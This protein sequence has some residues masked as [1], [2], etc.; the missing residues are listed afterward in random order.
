MPVSLTGIM[1]AAPDAATAER[2]WNVDAATAM[3][4]TEQ[5]AYLEVTGVHRA[6]DPE[7]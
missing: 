1:R 4:L 7:P 2:Q 6:A 3:T 5:G